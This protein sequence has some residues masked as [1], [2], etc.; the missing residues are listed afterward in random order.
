MNEELPFDI[1]STIFHHP[2]WSLLHLEKRNSLFV[3]CRDEN[4][5]RIE[6]YECN[7]ESLISKKLEIEVS[8]LEK[9]V[10]FEEDMLYSL[11][12]MNVD[13]PSLKVLKR[14][15]MNTKKVEV[16]DTLPVLNRHIQE[17]L[18]FKLDS[19]GHQTIADF[20]ALELQLSCEYLEFTNN[21]VIS[22]Y[23]RSGDVFDRFLLLI[24]EGK[25]KWKVRQDHQMKGFSS[26]AFF[27]VEGKLVFV[28]DRNEVCIYSL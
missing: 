8:W 14:T 11:E 19:K 17:A 2:I 24:K 7:M 6:V 22:Y 3:D 9:V 23:L 25:K 10:G 12:Y 5:K 13:D 21:I 20:L 15:N 18:L 27:V 1:R 28:K 16:I 26:G 4:K